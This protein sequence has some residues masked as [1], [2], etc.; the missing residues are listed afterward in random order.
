MLKIPEQ[1]I[2]TQLVRLAG[3]LDLE[4]PAQAQKPGTL[5]SS[6]NMEC[7]LTGGYSRIEGYE[8]YSGQP[9]PSAA[10]YE[11][12][13]LGS[14]TVSA[15]DTIVGGTSGATGVVC[16]SDGVNIAY[17]KGSGTFLLGED[18][19][20]GAVTVSMVESLSG[21]PRMLDDDATARALAANVYRDDIAEP[22]GEG[23]I[24]GGAM[25]NGDVY[26]WRKDVDLASMSIYKATP[27]G[28]VLVPLLWELAFTTGTTLY[29]EGSTVSKG[30]VT[31]VVRRVVHESGDWGTSN[32]A[33]R[34]IVETPSGTFTAGVAAGGGGCTLTGAATRITLTNCTGP[35]ETD[36]WN[37]GPGVRLYG[38]D[39]TNRAFEF[40]GAVLVP[41]NTGFSPDTPSHVSVLGECLMLAFTTSVAYSGATKPYK[42]S[43]I[44]GAGELPVNSAVT[45][46]MR[47][48]GNQ[49]GQTLIVAGESFTDILY[50]VP[51]DETSFKRIP[52]SESAGA[53][54]NTGQ[55][56]GQ[57]FML[58][59]GGVTSLAATQAYGNFDASSVTLRVSR[60]IK[61]RVN[62]AVAS[63]VARRKSQYR[64]LFSD[65]WALYITNANGK[66]LGCMPVE[67]GQIPTCAWYGTAEDGSERMFFGAKNGMVY[68]L[69]AGTSFDGEPIEWSCTLQW[70]GQGDH[71]ARKRYRRAILEA[72]C[73][74]YAE[75]V[76]STE[77]SNA[78]DEIAP[79][80]P[81]SR[82]VLSGGALV[83]DIGSW[84]SGL[85]WD[86]VPVS[87]IRVPLFGTGVNVALTISGTSN[88]VA[89]HTLNSVTYHYNLRRMQR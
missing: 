29:A 5:Q 59:D 49:A 15:G 63:V 46:M 44:E 21:R 33:G 60:F 23:G 18:I 64:I 88:R 19:L 76:I 22:P 9:E 12:L 81:E 66:L 48:V 13:T 75:M 40:D 68:R 77:F 39:G 31:A 65:G 35:V 45:M 16:Q 28:W 4:T 32:A 74:G 47:E 25:L 1:P 78:A 70:D 41:I 26:A 10:T 85:N 42:W 54:S 61:P 53:K 73:T 3:G 67:L 24:L 84:D 38:V 52:F 87:P 57:S 34:L 71:T 69:D 11:Q 58:D 62:M 7:A 72:Q 50:G 8:R 37:F 79:S 89:A 20:V 83:W 14:A 43:V 55:R 17:T 36:T 56:M 30:G 27:A 6:V 80:V 51:G 82:Q 86:G 2:R